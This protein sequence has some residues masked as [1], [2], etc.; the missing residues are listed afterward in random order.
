MHSHTNEP[1]DPT[2]VVTLY[3]R[4][5]CHL[6][7]EAKSQIAPLVAEFGVQ[8]REVDIDGDP[9]LREQYNLD[10]PVIFLGD[11]KIAKHRVDLLQFRR[12]LMEARRSR[13]A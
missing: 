10:V 11:R 9:K 6:C 2:I 5:G 3:S 8:L 4:P 1:G 7:D 12:Q 13:K